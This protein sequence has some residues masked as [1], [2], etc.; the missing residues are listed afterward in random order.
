MGFL[1]RLLGR[2]ARPNWFEELD[3]EAALFSRRKEY[4]DKVATTAGV[5]RAITV[6]APQNNEISLTGTLRGFP[7]RLVIDMDGAVDRAGLRCAGSIVAMNLRYSPAMES[8][9]YQPAPGQIMLA[10]GIVVEGAR[11]TDEAAVFH[12]LSA[13]FQGRLL[14]TVKQH[15]IAS[16][17]SRPHEHSISMLDE[18]NKIP[19]PVAW[20]AET[21]QL[22]AELANLRGCVAPTIVS[23]TSDP[24]SDDDDEWPLANAIAPI[25][26]AKLPDAKLT[27][28]EEDTEIDI[29][30]EA[31]GLAHK[32]TLN[33]GAGSVTVVV[34]ADGVEGTFDLNHRAEATAQVP[35]Q[36]EKAVPDQRVFFAPGIYFEGPP[37]EIARNAALLRALPAELLAE[38]VATMTAQRL[39][40][41]WL[42]DGTLL[43]EPGNLEDIDDGGARVIAIARLIGRVSSALPRG[44]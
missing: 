42:Q 5:E 27:E 23:R 3:E 36:E 34:A 31:L 8:P 10:P 6:A 16:I 21:L 40:C 14:T 43:V 33:G 20:L 1:D 32:L 30:W 9:K 11:A 29:E 17:Q 13:S 38:L 24:E 2:N 44:G 35:D 26:A 39:G 22:T 12:A 25:I 19:D 15:R 41:L 4:L 37:D 18:G 7:L 28:R